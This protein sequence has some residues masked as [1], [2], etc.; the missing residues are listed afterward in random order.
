MQLDRRF[1]RRTAVWLGLAALVVL[2]NFQLQSWLGRRALDETGL[3]IH[4]LE[5]GLALAS[6]QDK[7]VLAGLSAIWCSSCRTFDR[8]VLADE[9]V[10]EEIQKDFVFVRVEYRSDEGVAFR[11]RYGVSG[12][13]VFLVLDPDGD[14]RRPLPTTYQAEE[15]LRA[16]RRG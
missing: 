4:S 5:E 13:P 16:L 7:P 11:E 14:L 10:R 9:R 1:L 12:F 2:G 6:A 15:F 8:D 3:E